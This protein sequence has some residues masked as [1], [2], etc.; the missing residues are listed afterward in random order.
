LPR[1][2]GP[3]QTIRIG[4]WVRAPAKPGCFVLQWDLLIEQVA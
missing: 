1:N 2:R 3:D 4:A